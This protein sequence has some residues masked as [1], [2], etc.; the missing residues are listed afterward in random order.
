MQDQSS[1]YVDRLFNGE[2][3]DFIRSEYRILLTEVYKTYPTQIT[4][5][6]K[7]YLESYVESE[8][9]FP[10]QHVFLAAICYIPWFQYR[11][12]K[13]SR[14]E[15]DMYVSRLKDNFMIYF[16][17]LTRSHGPIQSE[18]ELAFPNYE[19][20]DLEFIDLWLSHWDQ[21]GEMRATLT[22]T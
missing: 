11:C 21:Y 9:L 14:V 8:D 7:V 19:F 20:F 15:F 3:V 10:M 18:K 5:D 2:D 22:T 13:N 1:D 4:P 16:R 12:S 17:G 6:I